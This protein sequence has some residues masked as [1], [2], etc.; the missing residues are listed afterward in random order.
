ML[1]ALALQDG[2][3]IWDP[4]TDACVCVLE[5]PSDAWAKSDP[6]LVALLA[7]ETTDAGKHVQQ[8]PPLKSICGRKCAFIARTFLE[9]L[10]TAHYDAPNCILHQFHQAFVL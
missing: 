1:P 9:D 8:L 10:K 3:N 6:D 5:P 4:R 7:K 2:R